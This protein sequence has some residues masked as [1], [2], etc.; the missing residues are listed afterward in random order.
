MAQRCCLDRVIP[1]TALVAFTIA[2]CAAQTTQTPRHTAPSARPAPAHSPD[3][4]IVTA[5]AASSDASAPPS[6]AEGQAVFFRVCGP[7]HLALWHVPTGGSLGPNERD[8]DE[9][10][11]QI[12]QGSTSARG[13]MPAIDE[14]TLPE[15][16]MIALIEYLRSTRV[17]APRPSN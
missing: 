6:N 14:R 11:R 1:W 7:C 17:V 15:S 10:R 9:V 4:A 16:S 12:R 3:A 5:P 8:E 13:T 2:A